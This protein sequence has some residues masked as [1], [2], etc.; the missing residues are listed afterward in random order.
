MGTRISA[1][2]S[3]DTS[4]IN[5][6]SPIDQGM[7]ESCARL[8]N[9]QHDDAVEMNFNGIVK[10]N[11]GD[12]T[13]NN[14]TVMS[15]EEKVQDPQ[16][17]MIFDSI[18]EVITYYK[19]YGRQSG[20]PVIKTS[21]T[22]GDDGNLKYVTISCA[23]E[24]KSK[25]R[26]KGRPPFKRRQSKIEQVIKKRQRTGRKTKYR[27]DNT[28]GGTEIPAQSDVFCHTDA[29][30]ICESDNLVGTQ[31]SNNVVMLLGLTHGGHPDQLYKRPLT[32]NITYPTVHEN[33]FQGDQYQN[34]NGGSGLYNLA[35]VQ[36]EMITKN[37]SENRSK[38]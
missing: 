23:R 27:Q 13:E 5:N 14:D 15:V 35:L 32:G 19:Q 31:E 10:E 3:E 28:D 18:D 29:P 21:S 4:H 30:P 38:S 8:E 7:E 9:N 17:G 22:N 12:E 2:E 1:S 6:N 11:N 26:S 36:E 37:S 33:Y 24:G 16:V 20:F 34:W 25:I